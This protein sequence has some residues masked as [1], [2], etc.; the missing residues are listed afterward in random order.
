M[1]RMHSGAKGRSRSK[2]PVSKKSPEWVELKPKEIEEAITSLANAGHSAAEIGT[3]LRDQYGVP[4]TKQVTEKTF[5][6]FWKS[7]I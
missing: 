4:S 7:T 3:L 5:H 6:K 1:A 2:K